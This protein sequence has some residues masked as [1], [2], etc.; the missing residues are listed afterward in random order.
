MQ[1]RILEDRDNP[2]ELIK[3]VREHGQSLNIENIVTIMHR[4]C[5]SAS[6]DNTRSR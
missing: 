4:Y 2:E 3:I 1:H 5:P 6:H